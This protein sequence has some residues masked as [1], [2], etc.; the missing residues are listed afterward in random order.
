[1]HTIESIV[2]TL[3]AWVWGPPMLTL[4][5]GT[6]LYLTFLLKGMQ[7]RAL[8]LALNSSFIKI[9]TMKATSVTLPH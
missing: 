8:P 7:F 2:A 1:M 5:L 3:S 9:I 4:L 6:G